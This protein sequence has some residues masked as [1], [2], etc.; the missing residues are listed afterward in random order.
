VSILR[1]GSRELVLSTP[2]VMGVLNVTPDSFSDGGQFVDHA[3][4]LRGA[5]RMLAA[6][7]SLIDLGGE[8]TRPG[9]TP[10]PADEELRRV[11]PLVRELLKIGAIVSID[12]RKPEVMRACIDAGVHMV[13]DVGAL[14]APGALDIVA[15]SD[16]AVC[17]MHM[18]G[19][20]LTMQRE[21]R[22]SD[23]VAEVRAFL[24]QRVAASRAAGMAAARLLID[25]GFGFGKTVTHN[26]DLLRG[27]PTL[28]ADG[29]PILVGL[30]R[31]SM[32]ATLTG[33]AV[34][35]RLAGSLALA[36]AALEGGAR[37]IRCHDVA[38]TV[39]AIRVWTAFRGDATANDRGG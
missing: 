29:V 27:L 19:E 16:V 30:S 15:G 24:Q 4:A 11:L 10:V 36:I 8:S 14:R 18:Q 13:N 12:T 23:V 21:P 25:P 34:E 9:A 22:Y 32:L 28:A 7:A 38:E 1:C 6:G 26:L 17:L 20:P 39:D 33:R 37:I 31:K 2:L 3:A 5:E 35:Q